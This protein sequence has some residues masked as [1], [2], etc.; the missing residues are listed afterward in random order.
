MTIESLSSWLGDIRQIQVERA[1]SEFRSARPVIIRE[2]DQRVIA[3]PVEALDEAALAH[4]TAASAEPRLVV[5][6]ARMRRLFGLPGNGAVRF[7]QVTLE[8]ISQFLDLDGRDQ[9]NHTPRDLPE[10]VSLFAPDPL[11]NA[12][13]T[14]AN[15]S[16][17]LPAVLVADAA[18]LD[19]GRDVPLQTVDASWIASYRDTEAQ[20]LQLV[21]RTP[22]PLEG[23]DH[24]EFVVF[25][26]G[27]GFRDHVAIVI[28]KPSPAE[29]V[30]ARI[31][32]A[33][34][35][36]DLFG[37]LKC[38]CGDQL[39]GTV[40]HMSEMGGG[41]VLYL[42]Q[43]GRGNGIA[44]KIRAYGLQHMGFDT[45][46][47]DEVLG[48][49][50]DQRRFDFA[51]QMLRLLGYGSV[52]LMT[53]NPQKIDALRNA[54]L[55]V[56]SSLRVFARHNP[57]NIKYLA[58]KRDRAGHLLGDVGAEAEQAPVMARAVGLP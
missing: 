35:T 45:F 12:A 46:D 1:F 14:L 54:G 24:A 27:D 32:S 17:L 37:S 47:A 44:N 13:L 4:F 36:G 15:L 3:L 2:G 26:G 25:R 30:L 53:N 40:R 55:E 34:L 22:V 9:H 20:R 57:H 19:N 18:M 6:E 41:I 31:H 56:V 16:L 10:T 52:R 8:G 51:A 33:C 38:D 39:R 5:S 48:F 23:V 58:A 7:D 50:F 11:E 28:S 29:P 21:A 42:D 49:G 43:E